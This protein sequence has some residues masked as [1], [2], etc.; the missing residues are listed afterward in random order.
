MG[1]CRP[2]SS[3]HLRRFFAAPAAHAP[4]LAAIS[5]ATNNPCVILFFIFTLFISFNKN[6][7]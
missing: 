3:V 6:G 2:C 7:P 4:A 5:D 1:N